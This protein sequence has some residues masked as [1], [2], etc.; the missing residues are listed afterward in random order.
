MANKANR[1]EGGKVWA[2]RH[3]PEW[4]TLT[5]PALQPDVSVNGAAPRIASGDPLMNVC[6]VK[7]WCRSTVAVV[8]RSDPSARGAGAPF[9]YVEA[10]VIEDPHARPVRTRFTKSELLPGGTVTADCVAHG[11]H[12]VPGAALL[13]RTRR[14]WGRIDAGERKVGK[15]VLARRSGK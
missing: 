13:A 8:W 7:C 3:E 15:Y 11:R 12:E 1:H 6:N 10:Q 4:S 14:A 9:Y 2:A 5:D